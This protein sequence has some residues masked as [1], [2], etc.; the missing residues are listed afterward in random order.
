M[1]LAKLR[2]NGSQVRI[3]TEGIVS[4]YFPKSYVEETCLPILI[5]DGEIFYN[6]TCLRQSALKELLETQQD[7]TK[8]SMRSITKTLTSLRKAIEEKNTSEVEEQN[9]FLDVLCGSFKNEVKILNLLL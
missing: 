2:I 3:E 5:R 7:E 6:K 4:F 8:R 9:S 1:F